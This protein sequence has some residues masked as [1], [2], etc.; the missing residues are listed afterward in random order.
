MSGKPPLFDDVPFTLSCY[1]CDC[2]SPDSYEEAIA[3]GWTD[4]QFTPDG[5]A[6]NYLGFCPECAVEWNAPGPSGGEDS[7]D[8]SSG[9]S[10]DVQI[11][12]EPPGA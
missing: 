1:G 10:N 8:P 2:D 7:I 11:R 12:Q 5:L 4:I 6:E 3:A 9:E